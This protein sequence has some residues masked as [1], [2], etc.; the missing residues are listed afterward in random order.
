M[1]A[2]NGHIRAAGEIPAGETGYNWRAADHVGEIH[3]FAA[4]PGTKNID[5]QYGM[6]EVAEADAIVTMRSSTDWDVYRTQNI[7]QAALKSEVS[8]GGVV[9]GR[10]QHKLAGQHAMYLLDP[11]EPQ[12]AEGVKSWVAANVI[13]ADDGRYDAA[14]CTPTPTTPA[15]A[16]V[17]A[18]APAAVVEEV[19]L[20]TIPVKQQPP[21]A[22]VE[23][24]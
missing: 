22:Y 7:F 23:P 16:P 10:L 13:V 18:V 5:T 12:I 6:K 20:V 4:Q 19:P 8:A 14:N 2:F 24:F 21:A 3:V 17:A 11:L 15:P 1:V 9:I